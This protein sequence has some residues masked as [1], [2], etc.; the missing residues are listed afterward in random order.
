MDRKD[1]DELSRRII[2]IEDE[3]AIRNPMARFTD[4]IN[5][6]DLPALA[7]VQNIYRTPPNL[8]GTRDASLFNST[9]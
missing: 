1:A 3:L 8:N 7:R 6:R 9:S 2:R 4:A 5:E